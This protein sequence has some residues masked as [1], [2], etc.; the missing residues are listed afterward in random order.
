[1]AD[2]PFGVL[3]ARQVKGVCKAIVKYVVEVKRHRSTSGSYAELCFRVN[4]ECGI[5][6]LQDYFQAIEEHRAYSPET[7]CRRFRERRNEWEQERN[8]EWEKKDGYSFG[9]PYFPTKA[10]TEKRAKRFLVFKKFYSPDAQT[11]LGP[12]VDGGVGL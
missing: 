6:T 8:P 5:R 3:M 9:N 10:T 4:A 2:V 7:I 12:Y 11:G 1:M